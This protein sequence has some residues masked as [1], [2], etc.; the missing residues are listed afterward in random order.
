MKYITF[1]KENNKFD[2]ILN[3]INIKKL[4]KQKTTWYQYLMI[5]MVD[6]EKVISYITLKYGDYIKTNYVKDHSPVI[7]VDYIPKKK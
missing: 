2:D 5:S 4:I 7:N 1:Y 6:D 3:D